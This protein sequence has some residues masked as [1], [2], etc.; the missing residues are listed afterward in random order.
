MKGVNYILI[1]L[2]IAASVSIGYMLRK[3]VIE[4]VDSPIKRDTVWREIVKR[5]TIVL[6]EP[7]TRFIAKI[8]TVKVYLPGEEK[9]VPVRLDF[10]ERTYKG[11]YYTAVVYGYKPELRKI[12][13]RQKER[14][15]TETHTIYSTKPPTVQ[16]GL[17]AGTFLTRDFDS[18][19]IAGNVQYN[20]GRVSVGAMAGYDPFNDQPVME[21]RI[22]IDLFRQ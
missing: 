2:L 11:E 22:G 6:F 21:A 10:E 14:T 13:I 4:Y 8:E 3:P 17:V 9:K 12:D 15:I 18:Q 19:Y 20:K 5:D 1:G 7:E 16:A